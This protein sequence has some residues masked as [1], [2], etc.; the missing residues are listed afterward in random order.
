MAIFVEDIIAEL[1]I[2]LRTIKLWEK[3][4]GLIIKTNAEGLKVYNVGIYNLFTQTQEMLSV[5][6]D[7]KQIRKELSSEIGKYNSKQNVRVIEKSATKV[8]NN[9]F[10]EDEDK[11]I[12]L[13][14]KLEKNIEEKI[15]EIVEKG[16]EEKLTAESKTETQEKENNFSANKQNDIEQEDIVEK[17]PEKAQSK[18]KLNET[19]SEFK[20]L[21]EALMQEL[22]MY[23]ERTIAAEKK[24]LLLEDHESRADKEY[25]EM[26]TEIKQLK[27]QIDEKNSK[28]KEFEAQKKR[29]SLVE[30]QLKLMQ[31]EKNKKRFW[32]FWK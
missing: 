6:F 27:E 2:D 22:R 24:V 25:F 9:E 13:D 11:I 17:V 28:I 32:E 19:S 1:G 31:I 8:Y 21:I 3:S 14:D 10:E 4:L 23:T 20:A 7:L 15:E 30:A 29:L 18:S 26:N 16:I 5:G 12:L